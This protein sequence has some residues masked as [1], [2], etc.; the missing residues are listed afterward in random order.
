MAPPGRGKQRGRPSGRRER[1]GQGIGG[2]AVRGPQHGR[3]LLLHV[4]GLAQPV[5]RHRAPDLQA[6]QGRPWRRGRDRA[7]GR[8]GDGASA[9]RAKAAATPS[10]GGDEGNAPPVLLAHAWDGASDLTGWWLSE[11]LDGVRAYW[12]GTRFL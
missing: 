2:T 10:A 1:R 4:P 12:D 6:H 7:R 8:R 9:P 3:R 11:K 5:D